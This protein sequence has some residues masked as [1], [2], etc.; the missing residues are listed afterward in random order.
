[1]LA[2]KLLLL[3]LSHMLDKRFWQNLQVPHAIWKEH[4]TRSPSLRVVTAG[5]IRSTIPLHLELIS[6]TASRTHMNSCPRMSPFCKA[7]ISEWYK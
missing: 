4:T 5:P 7:N 6:Y 1:M 3:V 2:I